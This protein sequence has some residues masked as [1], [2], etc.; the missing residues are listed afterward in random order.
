MVPIQPAQ[1][2][3]ELFSKTWSLSLNQWAGYKL[4]QPTVHQSMWKPVVWETAGHRLCIFT[5]SPKLL[6]TNVTWLTDK[7]CVMLRLKESR[8]L[9]KRF[10]CESYVPKC[11]N[12]DFCI[13]IKSWDSENSK[14]TRQVKAFFIKKKLL[15][16][17]CFF[18]LHSIPQLYPF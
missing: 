2:V 17:L 6:N 11:F 3:I 10:D 15:C 7:W 9:E 8:I 13:L 16:I 12:L 1:P 5:W 4:Q 14:A 18:R